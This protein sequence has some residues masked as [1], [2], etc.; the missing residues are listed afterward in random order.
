MNVFVK[1]V[2]SSVLALALVSSARAA[3]PEPYELN[4]ILSLT[5]TAAESGGE[6]AE[7]LR[8]L[9]G[10]VNKTGGI[11]GR[12][13]KFVIADDGSSPQVAVQLVNAVIAKKA[14]V[15]L[16]SSVTGT[17][18]AMAPLIAAN[19]PVMYCFAPGLNPSAGS[20]AFT[21]SVNAYNLVKMVLNYARVRGWNR[22]ALLMTTDATGQELDRQFAAVMAEP[23]NK[24]VTT[25]AHEHFTAADIS[26]T[27]QVARIKSLNPQM[28]VIWSIGTPFGTALRGVH[29]VGLQVPIMASAGDMTYAQ[30]TQYAPFLTNETYF[31][32]TAAAIPAGM[33][34]AGPVREAQERFFGAL[35]AAGIHPSFPHNLA[36][37]P[38]MLIVAALRKIGPSATA[39]QIHEYIENTHGV[40][41]IDGVYDFA[42]G[43]QRGVGLNAA[44]LYKWDAAKKDF[45]QV[46]RGN[47]KP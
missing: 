41:G 35:H 38:G 9:E 10:V 18:S 4:A 7:S 13:L 33:A 5:G 15:F 28:L 21:A 24:G 42:D 44:R 46:A 45:V 39:A 30:M 40:V 11:G 43:S 23:E 26:V 19:G 32:A 12:P 1:A 3:A 20:Y 14:P 34:P 47:G 8:T 36:W 17:C 29:D 22:I 27:A 6:E 31:P 37:D 2:C 16:G 25:V